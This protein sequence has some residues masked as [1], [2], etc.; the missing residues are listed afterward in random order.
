MLKN[1]IYNYIFN[2]VIKTFFIVLFAFTVIAWAAR[3]VNFLDLIVDNGVSFKTYML[4][5][6]FQ[7]SN[8][9]TKFVPVS[10]LLAL[11]LSIIKLKKNNELLILWLTGIKKYKIINFFFF[12]S[13]LILIFQFTLGTII[14]PYLLQKSRILISS[15]PVQILSTVIKSNTFSDSFEGTTIYTEKKTSRNELEKITIIDY[16][17][18]FQ[19]LSSN[20]EKTSEVIIVANTGLIDKTKLYLKNG[21]IQT[22]TSDNKLENISFET[23]ELPLD[24]L[25]TRTIKKLK[26]Q[27][28]STKTLFNCLNNSDLNEEIACPRNNISKNV[29][30]TLSRRMGMPLYIPFV[31]LIMSFLLISNLRKTKFVIYKNYFYFFISFMILV[32]AEVM[33]RFT[34]FSETNLLLYVFFPMIMCPIIYIYLLKQFK[35]ENKIT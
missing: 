2:E 7:L 25:S 23:L 4:Y 27:E 11:T 26:L 28:I 13:V 30:E 6:G 31:S 24:S 33:V 15:T 12:L 21:I 29:T 9:L 3:A 18:N 32:T 1:K 34:G 22:K 17:K 16:S 19:S 8:I 35:K 10:F 14:T 5:T 20:P